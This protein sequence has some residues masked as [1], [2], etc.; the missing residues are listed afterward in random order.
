[1]DV[2]SMSGPM[3]A[4]YMIVIFSALGFLLYMFYN[5]LVSKKEEEEVKR[6]AKIEAKRAKKSGKKVN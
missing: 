1:M 4:V 3:Q 2:S 5:K 6:L